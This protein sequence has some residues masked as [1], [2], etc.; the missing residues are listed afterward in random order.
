LAELISTRKTLAANF[1]NVFPS[2]VVVAVIFIVLNFLLTSFASWLEGRIRRGKRGTG[3]VVTAGVG[4]E[5]G[6]AGAAGSEGSAIG[7]NIRVPT[8][9]TSS[10][11]DPKAPT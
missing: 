7:L 3:A 8:Q 6:A 9:P 10:T 1:A 2:F 11:Y 5:L 4:D